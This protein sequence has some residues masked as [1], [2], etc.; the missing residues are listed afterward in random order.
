MNYQSD[1]EVLLLSVFPKELE[2]HA[3]IKTCI[4]PH[5]AV[6]FFITEEWK[7]S[8]YSLTGKGM[9][10]MWHSHLIEYSSTVKSMTTDTW[11]QHGWTLKMLSERR[12]T[13]RA[14]FC[15]ILWI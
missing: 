7:Q 12:H 5:I 1:P 14:H 9:Y 2:I 13:I 15:L 8:K 4:W 11:L 3:Y 10:K 6:L